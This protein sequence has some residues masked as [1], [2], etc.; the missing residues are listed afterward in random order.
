MTPVGSLGQCHAA[1]T[2][3]SAGKPPLSIGRR[4]RRT[5]PPPRAHARAPV[6]HEGEAKPPL[7]ATRHIKPPA[8]FPH[9]PEQP[10][11]PPP[12][13]IGATSD[14]AALLAPIANQRL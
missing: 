9:V 3:L 12:R 13:A 8:S 5:S 10:R 1:Y 4:L 14:L 2:H 6:G 11:H 7:R